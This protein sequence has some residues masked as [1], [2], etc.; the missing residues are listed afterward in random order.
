[1]QAKLRLIFAEEE[2]PFLLDIS[3]LL[4]DFELLHDLSLMLCAEEYIDYKFSRRFW[5]RNGRPIRRDHRLRAAK[6]VKESPLTIE[7]ILA[8]ITVGSG[9]LWVLLQAIEKIQNWG[10]NRERLRLQVEKLRMENEKLRLEL[11][12]KVHQREAQYILDSLTTRLDSIPM[13]LTDLVIVPE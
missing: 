2:R 5:Y 6:I 1:M 7:L 8:G 11:E 12:P 3:S 4:Y 9:A 13:K 10:L